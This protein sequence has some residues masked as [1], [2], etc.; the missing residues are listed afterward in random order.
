M[1]TLFLSLPSQTVSGAFLCLLEPQKRRRQGTLKRWRPELQLFRAMGRMAGPQ[2]ASRR[3]RWSYRISHGGR[4]E[5]ERRNGRK[6]S[7]QSLSEQPFK[8]S[9][10]SMRSWTSSRC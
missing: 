7:P 6:P 5:F 4:S 9:S 8:L 2:E 3:L 10:P 1:D